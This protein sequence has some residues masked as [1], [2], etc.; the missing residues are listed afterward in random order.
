M[1]PL[2]RSESD[3]SQLEHLGRAR[4]AS[5]DEVHGHIDEQV[6][7]PRRGASQSKRQTHSPANPHAPGAEDHGLDRDTRRPPVAEQPERVR[8]PALDGA[9]Q[10]MLD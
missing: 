7:S 4:S 8:I 3:T 6:L 2:P 1:N 10:G 5:L 9:P